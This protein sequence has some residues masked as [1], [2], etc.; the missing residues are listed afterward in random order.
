M[1]S[2]IGAVVLLVGAL[3]LGIASVAPGLQSRRRARFQAYTGATAAV[4]DEGP[5]LLGPLLL[6]VLPGRYRAALEVGAGFSWKR[7]ADTQVGLALVGTGLGLLVLGLPGIIGVLLAPA[8]HYVIKLR[9]ARAYRHQFLLQ[10][11]DALLLLGSAMSAGRNFTNAL[12]ATVPNLPE[13]I[14][15]DLATLASRIEALQLRESQA[16]RMWSQ[17]L[18]YKELRTIA[19]ALEI[20][21]QVGLQTD[22][23][24]RS[25]SESIEGQLVARTEL[26]ALT[27]QVRATATVISYLPVGF[28]G[29]LYFIEP[30]FVHPLFSPTG[31]IIIGIGA[32]FFVISRYVS[33]Q[34]LVR[35]EAG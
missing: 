10:L 17:T 23:L 13:P 26:D 15:G 20:G 19:S 7:F 1:V 32:I 21:E 14:Q 24:L 2:M 30:G 4:A 33:G 12:A 16:F 5:G 31:A 34:I 29:L 3:Y 18:P 11:P 35:I 6:G 22:I 9:G 8:I 28:V 25:L 27:S